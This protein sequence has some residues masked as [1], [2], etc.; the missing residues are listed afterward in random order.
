L[1]SDEDNGQVYVVNSGTEAVSVIDGKTGSLVAT[2]S[3][4]GLGGFLGFSSYDPTSR[5]L[6]VVSQESYQAYAIDTLTNLVLEKLASSQIPKFAQSSP[7]H[8]YDPDNGFLYSLTDPLTLTITDASTNAVKANVTLP[9]APAGSM[10][11][12]YQYRPILYNPSNKEVYVYGMDFFD[13]MDAFNP[14]RLLAI[15][16][17]NNSVV[18]SIPVAGVGGGLEV[19]Y[20]FFSYDSSTGNVL[21]TTNLNRSSG[22]TG[23][24]QINNKNR[25]VSEVVLSGLPFGIDLAYDQNIHMLYAAYGGSSVILINPSS[26]V[27]LAKA[28]FGTCEY[29]VLP[30]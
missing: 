22:T 6:F 8:V 12:F 28:T 30:P 10:A 14:D 13:G 21:A 5:E 16:T 1:F 29:V 11:H 9:P 3:V 7:G 24:L 15:S 19:E 23:L 18:A 4:A 27:S 17:V 2:I 20:P 25:V 26:G